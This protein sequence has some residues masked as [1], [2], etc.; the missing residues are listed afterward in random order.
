MLVWSKPGSMESVG[1]AVRALAGSSA[2]ISI[3][4]RHEECIANVLTKRCFG[5]ILTEMMFRVTLLLLL[6]GRVAPV[7]GQIPLRFRYQQWPDRYEGVR[8]GT[9]VLGERLEVV[10]AVARAALLHSKS[11]DKLFVAFRSEAV[12]AVAITVR[13]LEKNYWMEPA[14]ARGKKI[15]GCHAGLNTFGWDGKAVRFLGLTAGDLTALVERGGAGGGILPAL[16]FDSSS[17]PRGEVKVEAY[18]FVVV[19]NAD[20]ADLSYSFESGT[21]QKLQSDNLKDLPTD[22]PVTL[23]WKPGAAAAGMY[24][25]TGTATFPRQGKPAL[26]QNFSKAFVHAAALRFQP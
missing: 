2:G 1:K 5:Y 15:S 16:L 13:D 23:R 19:P 14:D 20:V 17:A 10:S 21:G 6:L 9:Q 7:A 12:G 4:T 26:S 25:L 24:R 18:E 11:P 22:G 8:A 3:S